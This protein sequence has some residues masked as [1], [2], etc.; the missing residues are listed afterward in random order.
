I[1]ALENKNQFKN[2]QKEHE[3]SR[4]YFHTDDIYD[5]EK[6]RTQE[7]EK[8][9]LPENRPHIFNK[10][11][12][13]ENE[14]FPK[15]PDLL[16]KNIIENNTRPDGQNLSA[17]QK[18]NLQKNLNISSKPSKNSE[19]QKS[20]VVILS[21][22]SNSKNKDNRNKNKTSKPVNNKIKENHPVTPA[23]SSTSNAKNPLQLQE[24]PVKV[25]AVNAKDKKLRIL[26]YQTII[27]FSVAGFTIVLV[28]F[29]KVIGVKGSSYG[30]YSLFPAR[31]VKMNGHYGIIDQGSN[32]GVKVDDILRLYRKQG[33]KIVFRG[34][35]HVIKVAECYSAVELTKSYP[36]GHLKVG[37]VGF[38][39][40]NFVLTCFKRIRIITSAILIDLAKVLAYVAKKFDIKTEKPSVD[41]DI[42]QDKLESAV[43]VKNVVKNSNNTV[44][45]NPQAENWKFLK[46]EEKSVHETNTV[47][48]LLKESKEPQ[49]KT[50]IKNDFS[51]QEE[52]I[53]FRIIEDLPGSL[54]QKHAVAKKALTEIPQTPNK[55]YFP[56]VASVEKKKANEE[57]TTGRLRE[58]EVSQVKPNP[59]QP[60]ETFDLSALEELKQTIS[61][62]GVIQPIS[63]RET[64]SGYELIGGERRLRAVRELGLERIVAYVLEIDNKEEMLQLSLIENIQRENLNPIDEANGYQTLISKCHLTQEEIAQKVGKD[65]ATIANLIR[66]LKLPKPIQ[67]SLTQREISAGH[68]RALLTL[69]D[70]GRQIEI[71]QTTLEKKY[72]VRQVEQLIRNLT[73]QSKPN[74]TANQVA[75]PDDHETTENDKT[76]LETQVSTQAKYIKA[77]RNLADLG[78]VKK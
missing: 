10:A 18:K 58:V 51:E 9:A 8:M 37:D 46:F 52:K 75:N 56:R 62:N 40:R 6:A 24:N 42:M 5:E 70:P 57:G 26:R 69:P 16:S 1:G 73:K 45:E 19:S 44:T 59:F 61:E 32:D 49:E 48:N 14:S 43:Q 7:P 63:V 30:K 77:D 27:L 64:D 36:N 47:Q 74:K 39:D 71:W 60:R 22:K 76:K 66:L 2:P 72:S 55:N 29:L 53:E 3:I 21:R 50:N 28:I 78:G 15:A 23:F 31:L 25:H 54:A 11:D 67:N 34:K 17:N 41:L 13:R 38:R 65:R 68:A 4:L 35:V 12:E 33:R 20:A